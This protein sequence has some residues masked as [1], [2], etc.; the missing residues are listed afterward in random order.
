[1]IIT[2]PHCLSSRYLCDECSHEVHHVKCAEPLPSGYMATR[3]AILCKNIECK[4][5]GN[6]LFESNLLNQNKLCNDCTAMRVY[7]LL[8]KNSSIFDTMNDEDVELGPEN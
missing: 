4:Y 2:C 6:F 8:D 1:M 7:K 3:V 5:Y